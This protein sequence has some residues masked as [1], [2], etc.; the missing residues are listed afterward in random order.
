MAEKKIIV[1]EKKIITNASL[2][3]RAVAFI[4]ALKHTKGEWHGKNF[5]LLPWQEKVVRDVFGTVKENGYRQYNTAYI[6]IPKK[7]ASEGIG[8]DI[9]LG[10]LVSVAALGKDAVGLLNLQAG[11]TAGRVEAAEIRYDIADLHTPGSVCIGQDRF[12][13]HRFIGMIR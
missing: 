12:Q 4:S 7:Q 2:A 6:E 10:L 3:D 5:V 9:P 11:L 1:P 13:Q 8:E